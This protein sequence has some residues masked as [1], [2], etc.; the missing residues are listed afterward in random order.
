MTI[1][2][3]YSSFLHL[4]RRMAL[5]IDLG[6]LHVHLFGRSVFLMW[7]TVAI[8]AAAGI[9][10]LVSRRP[11]LI[12]KW[13]TWVL[14]APA[15]GLPVWFGH[16]TTAVLAAVLAVVAVIEYARLVRLERADTYVLL[17]LAVLYPLAAWLRP[18]LLQLAP[19]VLLLCALPSVLGGDVENGARRTA[20]TAFGSVW[21]C[22]S[23]SH[24]VMVLP[25]TYLLCFAVAATDVAAWC[26]GK[27]LR[28]MA[29]ARRP[30]SPLSPNKTVG[31]LV[32][33]IIGAFVILS[34]LGSM[35]IGLLVAVSIGGVFGDLLESMLKRQAQVKDA[36]D[37][38][39]GFGGLLDRIDSLLLVLPLA[40]FLG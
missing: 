11:E 22:W 34:L 33:A 5:D 2:D 28:R 6:P 20:F 12:Q 16:G 30:L 8:L 38:L 1:F 9:A 13:R 21:I 24:L 25:D 40:Y 18:T 29:W 10:V 4:D 31:G 19:V 39:P 23:L 36:G 26:G 14:I 37:W 15:V 32:G 17:A 35:S 3:Q 27:G 7:I